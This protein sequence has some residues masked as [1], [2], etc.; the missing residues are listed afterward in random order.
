MQALFFGYDFQKIVKEYNGDKGVR[1]FFTLFEK[2][3]PDFKKQ[4]LCEGQL[5]LSF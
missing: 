5:L 1:K 4:N 3:P 2:S